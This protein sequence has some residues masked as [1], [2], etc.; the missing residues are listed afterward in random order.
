ME[1]ELVLSHLVERKGSGKRVV[2]AGLRCPREERLKSVREQ[3]RTG[4]QK[5]TA[6]PFLC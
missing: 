6:F 3:A 2:M 1:A 5:Y 4:L